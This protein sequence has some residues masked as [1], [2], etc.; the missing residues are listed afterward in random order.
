MFTI[1]AQRMGSDITKLLYFC[2]NV[3]LI[4]GRWLQHQL[5]ANDSS[6]N[7]R[8]AERNSQ[9]IKNKNK[10]II[11]DVISVDFMPINKNL[12]LIVKQYSS[13]VN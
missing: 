4:H 9:L 2:Y 8:S 12:G 6:L 10:I 7:P 1:A 11:L 3:L 5:I 13:S